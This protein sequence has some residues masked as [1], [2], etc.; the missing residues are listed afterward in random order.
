MHGFPMFLCGT[1]P[2][3]PEARPK[4]AC[5]SAPP[6]PKRIRV[7]ERAMTSDSKEPA[8]DLLVPSGTLG[9]DDVMR[10]GF[11]PDGLYLVEGDP[12]S[13]KTTL[14]L[15]FMLDGVKRGERCLY[16]TLS[17]DEKE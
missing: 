3:A 16:V 12:G 14:A 9:L 6:R 8:V 5:A 4:M 10:G 2:I 13:G 1:A 17:E 11:T 7:H 15:Q